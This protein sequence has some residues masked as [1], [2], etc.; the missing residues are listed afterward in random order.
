[1]S[2]STMA[3]FARPTSASTSPVMKWTTLSVSRLSY[4]SPQRSTGMRFTIN[5]RRMGGWSEGPRPDGAGSHGLATSLLESRLLLLPLN[6][7]L[8]EALKSLFDLRLKS[9]AK[10]R[11]ILE[12]LGENGFRLGLDRLVQRSG[13]RLFQSFFN[14]HVNVDRHWP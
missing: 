4:G 9:L 7:F 8:E 10:R 13:E 6:A 11:A 12:R 1:M 5:L 14:D 3:A 2:R